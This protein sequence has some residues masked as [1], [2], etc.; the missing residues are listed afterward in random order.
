LLKLEDAVSENGKRMTSATCKEVLGL[1]QD[2]LPGRTCQ[3]SFHCRSSMCNLENTCRGKL[4]D[5]NCF[6]N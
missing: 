5:A 2:L 4:K 1:R 6:E 3:Q